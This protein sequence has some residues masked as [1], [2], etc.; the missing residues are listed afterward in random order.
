MTI[1]YWP[2]P[3]AVKTVPFVPVIDFTWLSVMPFLNLENSEL[4][5]HESAVADEILGPTI[6]DKTNATIANFFI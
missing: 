3:A 2:D 5:T 4:E 6:V 1:R